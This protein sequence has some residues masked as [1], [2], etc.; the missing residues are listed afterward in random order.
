MKRSDCVHPQEWGIEVWGFQSCSNRWEL[1]VY[2]ANRQRVGRREIR[3]KTGILAL[4]ERVNRT[5]VF[6]TLG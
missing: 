1:S 4:D 3:G 6:E 2:T 5:A